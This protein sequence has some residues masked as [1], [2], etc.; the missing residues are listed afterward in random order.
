MSSDISAMCLTLSDPIRQAIVRIDRTRWKI[1]L[2]VDNERHLLGTITDGDVRRA[3]LAGMD[4]DS[5]VKTLLDRRAPTAHPTPLTASVGTSRA[6]LLSM[7]NEYTLRHIPVVDESGRVVDVV[8]LDDLVREE[9]LPLRAV[10]MA[11]GYGTRLRPITEGLPKPMLPI[12]DRP[13]LELTLQQLR[14]AGIKRVNLATH[15]KRDIIAN[16]FGDG[17]NFGVKIRYVEE[18]QPLG[19]AGA[20]GLIET[21]EDP[22][23]VINGDVVTRVDFHA[24]LDFHRH[25]RADMTVAVRQHEVQLPHG[26]VETDGLAITGISEKPIL[27]HFMNAGIYLLNPEMCRFVPSGRRYDMTDL[28]SRLIAEGC[29]VVSFPIREYWLDIGQVED[30]QKALRDFESKTP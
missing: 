24:M 23:L 15:Y 20:L 1:A 26:V 18:D 3:I 27:R 10:I 30:Y 29:R 19:T 21:S 7:M 22:L 2:V 25:H 14:D 28:I 8:L 13:L 5:P 4:L 17:H 12:G 11:G 6:D 16:H 9:E